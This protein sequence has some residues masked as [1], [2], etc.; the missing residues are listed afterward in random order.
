[1]GQQRPRPEED[2]LD[3]GAIRAFAMGFLD[4]LRDR[5]VTLRDTP[6]PSHAGTVADRG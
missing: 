1:M 6:D 5:E 2:G 3:D 4:G